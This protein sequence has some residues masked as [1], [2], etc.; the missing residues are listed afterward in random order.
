VI[1]DTWQ[2]PALK[3]IHK[4]RYHLLT[5][6]YHSWQMFGEIL[7]IRNKNIVLGLFDISFI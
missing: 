5:I 7:K 1:W 3:M 2:D 6:I 4:E